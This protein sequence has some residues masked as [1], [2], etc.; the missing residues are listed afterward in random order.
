MR[1]LV[2]IVAV[3]GCTGSETARLSTVS[4]SSGPEV[5]FERPT[6]HHFGALTATLDGQPLDV[7]DSVVGGNVDGRY[8]EPSRAWFAFSRDRVAAGSETEIVVTEDGSDSA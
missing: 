4:T 5:M 6:E 2:A 1:I 8:D 3:A 7:T